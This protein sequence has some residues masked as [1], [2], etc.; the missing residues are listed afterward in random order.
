MSNLSTPSHSL[1]LFVDLKSSISTPLLMQ[2]LPEL[3]TSM[4]VVRMRFHKDN[5]EEWI[6]CLSQKRKSSIN[7]HHLLLLLPRSGEWVSTGTLSPESRQKRTDRILSKDGKNHN[8]KQTCRYTNKQE[9]HNGNVLPK[10]NPARLFCPC[11]GSTVCLCI[12]RQNEED[13]E[14]SFI[15]TRHSVFS[16]SQTFPSF[17]QVTKTL[18]M[19]LASK[20]E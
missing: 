14:V 11:L 13:K 5:V 8:F 20:Q 4:C 16:V 17:S 19:F 7:V 10:Q 18:E 15:P 6:V 3:L 2:E 1:L 9:M 12:P